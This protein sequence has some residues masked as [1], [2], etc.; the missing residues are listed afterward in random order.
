MQYYIF[1]L[2]ALHDSTCNLKIQSTF[3]HYYG[4]IMQ[5]LFIYRRPG[6]LVLV[7]NADWELVVTN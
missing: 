1:N 6:I 2:V 5:S 7:N 4:K 3:N